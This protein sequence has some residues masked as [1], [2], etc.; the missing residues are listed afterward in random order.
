MNNDLSIDIFLDETNTPFA[1]Y[2]SSDDFHLSSDLEEFILSKLLN[3]KRREVDIFIKGENDYDDK[4]LKTAIV[5]TF[6]NRVE[7][8]EYIYHRNNTKAIVLYVFGIIVGL[9][10]FSLSSSY[11]YFA[12]ILSIVCWV[13]IWSGTEV[14]FFE[15]RQIKSDIRKCQNIINANVH[16]K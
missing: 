4:S 16:K 6:S 5:N 12:G 3:S 10:G 2:F 14:Y 15:N 9:I 7:E 8:N 13:F 11:T 1:P